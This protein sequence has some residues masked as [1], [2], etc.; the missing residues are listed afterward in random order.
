MGPMSRFSI[1]LSS[2]FR[3]R[4]WTW[5]LDNAVVSANTIRGGGYG[6][7]VEGT[8]PVVSGNTITDNDYPLYQYRNAFPV[9][10]GNTITGNTH[11]AIAVS[12]MI[13]S[14]TWVDVQGLPYVL[15]GD[16]WVSAGGT[17]VIP[18]G[19]VVKFES[20]YDDFIV[21]GILDLQGTSGSPVVFT[22]FKDDAYGGDTNG[23][24]VITGPLRGGLEQ[25]PVQQCQSQHQ[26]HL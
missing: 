12:Q 5:S 16:L 7:Q 22:S 1:A 20:Y 24:G 21:D 8:S 15:V 11:Q 2:I 4:R 25:D 18:A 17:L 9:Y 13:N 3:I 10:S 19:T 23:D 26:Q 14:G 6:I